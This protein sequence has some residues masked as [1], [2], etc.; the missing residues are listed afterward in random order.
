MSVSH[1]MFAQLCIFFS[2]KVLELVNGG[3]VINR[4]YPVQFLEDPGEAGL[5][6]LHPPSSILI[7]KF[8]QH[9]TPFPYHFLL[10]RER[11][12]VNILR[13]LIYSLN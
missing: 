2:F 1:E 6:P 10:W 7:L 13:R 11:G 8:P 9:S 4:A 12:W 5:D 3:S